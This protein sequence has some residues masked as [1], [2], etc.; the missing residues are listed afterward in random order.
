M[1]PDGVAELAARVGANVAR[2]V[3]V[4]PAVLEQLL[5]ALLAGGH[6]NTQPSQA[7]RTYT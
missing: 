4:Q 2:A 3:T 5:V 1:N 6:S 7:A